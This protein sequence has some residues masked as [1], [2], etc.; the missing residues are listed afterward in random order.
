[1]IGSPCLSAH[2]GSKSCSIPRHYVS[3]STCAAR[4]PSKAYTG[5][6]NTW[7]VDRVKR[8]QHGGNDDNYRDVAPAAGD[9]AL[10]PDAHQSDD[11]REESPPRR[12]AGRGVLPSRATL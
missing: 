10:A 1:M 9:A 8:R 3:E 2:Q 6:S 7:D 12:T 11:Q 5:V 4:Y